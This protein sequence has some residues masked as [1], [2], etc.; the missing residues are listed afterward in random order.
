MTD[1]KM[2]APRPYR[3]DARAEA[4]AET[5][6]R[7]L[8]A[9]I[10]IFWEQPADQISLDD[11]ARRAG[12]STRT[13]IRRFGGKEGLMAAAGSRAMERTR[14]ER[15]APVGDITAAVS[16]LVDH[17]EL[18]GDRVLRMLAAEESVAALSAIADQGRNLH[19]D[20]CSQVFEPTLRDLQP[21]ERR[22]RLAQLVALCDVYV[23]KL[24]RRDAGLSRGQ[25]ELAI[26]EMLRP[27]TKE[28]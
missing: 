27:L 6:A 15:A 14:T 25:T 9:A 3:M 23:W 19:R 13:V 11:V 17:Y 1:M 2:S 5:G 12:V 24:L 26:V 22:R 28:T 18:M 16:V 7:I 21:A 10:A 8:D 4:T 20:W